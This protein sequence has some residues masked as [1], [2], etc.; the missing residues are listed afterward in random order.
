MSVKPFK[1]IAFLGIAVLVMSVILLEVY[2][3][4][5][6]WLPKGF[7]SPILA[8]EFMQT[9]Q[10]VDLL[11][12]DPNGVGHLT[13]IRQMDRGNRLDIVYMLLY[14]TFLGLFALKCAQETN[15]SW[16]YCGVGLAGLMLVGDF[17]ENLQLFGITATLASN[18]ISWDKLDSDSI[19]WELGCL[20]LFTCLK[21][22]SLAVFFLALSPYFLKGQ[23]FVKIIGVFGLL[24]AIIG[25]VAYVHRSVWNEV[26]MYAIALMFILLSLYGFLHCSQSPKRNVL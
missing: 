26:F 24:P 10:E 1:Y 3:A 13:L 2:P 23:R 12:G 14:S 4:R 7:T 19:S 21:W 22:G 15:S 25:I 9:Q 6:P 16:Y 17:L 5:A 8:F 18:A 11:F 20:H